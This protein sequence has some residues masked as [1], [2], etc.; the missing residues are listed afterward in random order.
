MPRLH[1]TSALCCAPTGRYYLQQWNDVPAHPREVAMV[2]KTRRFA[3][4]GWLVLTLGAVAVALVFSPQW[5]RWATTATDQTESTA[6]INGAD[7]HGD[8]GHSEATSI[9]LSENGLKNIGFQPK[10]VELGTFVKTISLP[11]MITERPGRSQIEIAAPL[12]G[13]ITKIFPIHGAAVEPG[14]ALFTMRL[15]HEELVGAQRDLIRTSE[16]LAVVNREIDRLES[17]GEGIVAGQRILEKQYEKQRLVASLGAERQALVL[18]GLEPAQVDDILKN[19]KLLQLITVRAPQHDHEGEGCKDDHLF[20]VQELPVKPGQQIEAGQALAVLADHC[21][22]YIEGRAFED[23]ALLLRRAAREGWDVSA[24]VV[25]SQ[26]KPETVEGLKLMYLSDHVDAESRAFLFY[27]SLPNSV[28]MDRSSS[29][30]R[31]IEWRFKPGQRMELHVPVEQWQDRIVLPVDAIVDE[32]A[33]AY[34]YRQNGDHFDRVPVHVEYRDQNSVVI[35]NDGSLFPGDVV[36]A[37][38]AYQMHLALKNQAGGGVDPHAGHS[39]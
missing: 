35:A 32:G 6:Q 27:L 22:L 1:R 31:F 30:H 25:T 12:T 33:E 16:S 36:A 15:T 34:V 7:D 8:A 19:K 28:A 2:L 26:Q 23:D 38:G 10:T 37:R 4:W 14:G 39:H 29:G 3:T 21:E 11:A 24:S 20:H 13:V 18:H 17:L 5:W 9:E